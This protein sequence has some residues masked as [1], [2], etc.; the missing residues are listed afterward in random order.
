MA[1]AAPPAPDTAQLRE[2]IEHLAAIDRP[3]ASESEREAAEWIAGRLREQGLEPRIE[4]EPAH[5]TYWWPIGITAALGVLGGL[6]SLRGRRWLGVLLGAF[7]APANE[8]KVPANY[9]WPTDV[10][11]NVDYR[12]VA[13]SVKLC[14]RVIRRLA[15]QPADSAG[16]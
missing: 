4:E 3:P 10:P 15:E 11:E 16:E 7:A 5:G 1:V 12:G 9:H 6:A 8:F 14:E 2:V 13:D